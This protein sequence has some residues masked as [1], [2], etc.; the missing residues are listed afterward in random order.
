MLASAPATPR[1]IGPGVYHPTKTDAIC[2]P[3]SSLADLTNAQPLHTARAVRLP[4]AALRLWAGRG[5]WLGLVAWAVALGGLSLL[6]AEPGRTWGMIVLALAGV[7]GIV[8]WSQERPLPGLAPPVAG[9]RLITWDLTR[10]IGFAGVGL[11]ALL[12]LTANSRYLAAPNETFGLAGI[13]WLLSMIALIGATATWPRRAPA[14]T[15]AATAAPLTA[16]PPAWARW[17]VA[18]FLALVAL[19]L[20]VRVWDLRDFPYAIHGDEVLTG[21]T[22]LI[23]Y[24]DGRAAPVFS[25]LWEGINL[26]ALWFV[27]VATSLKLGGTTL[28]ALRLPAAL[29]G[30]ATVVPFYGLVRGAWGRTAALAGTTVLAVSAVHVHYSRLTINNIVAPFF[31]AVCFFFLLRGLRTRRPLDWVLAGLA[32]G[33]SEHFYYG[34]RLLSILLLAFGVYLLV[35]H[36]RQGWRLAG[37]FALL[38]LGWVAGF[39]PLLSYFTQHPGSYFGRGA[40]QG[41]LMWDH[42]PRDLADWQL[43][44]NTLWPPMANNLL[45]VSTISGQDSFYW[46]P[47]L[48]TGEAALLVLG[49]A[50]LIWQW[51]HPAAFLMLLSGAGVLFVGGTL[52][53]GTPFFVHWTPAFP[54]VYA[55]IAVPLGAWA[56][57]WRTVPYRW[58]IFGPTLLAAALVL[59]SANNLDFTFNR[60][61]IERP[62]FEIGAAQSRWEAALGTGYRVFV[63]GPTWQP[64]DAERN[65]Y[66]IQGQQGTTLTNLP[67]DL[68]VPAQPGKGL[69]FVVFPD[70]AQ[71]LA[72]VQRLYPHGTSGEVKS[73]SG[74]H[75]FYTY[76]VPP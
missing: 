74:I 59:N 12:I 43:M 60:Y 69:A 11:A 22:A 49:V 3:H 42:I 16:A 64:Y 28:E 46:A 10:A 52:I 5:V 70:Q 18:F 17:E 38:A 65:Q 32:A 34:T 47:L 8:A 24:F 72:V 62:E 27:G 51:R 50:L 26:P 36:W 58:Q 2:G 20:L 44:W 15:G 55:A 41:A 39:G 25:T 75:L 73:H 56:G 35:V 1:G 29:F 6:V 31:W 66:L 21:R 61:Y 71:Y 33:L 4:Q 68:P 53:H 54:A 40:E 19:A 37:H 23:G 7:L 13:L 30:A 14:A 76:L 57:S 9:E 48:F 63:L 45:G 67:T